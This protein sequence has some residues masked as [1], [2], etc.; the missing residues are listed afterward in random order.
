VIGYAAPAPSA[1]SAALEALVRLL[2]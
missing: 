2:P 1:W